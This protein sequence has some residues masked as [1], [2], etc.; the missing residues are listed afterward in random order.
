MYR[1]ILLLVSTLSLVCCRISHNPLDFNRKG[2]YIGDQLETLD[3]S[4]VINGTFSNKLDHFGVATTV[5]N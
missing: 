1:T 2:E 5:W 4:D 3:L